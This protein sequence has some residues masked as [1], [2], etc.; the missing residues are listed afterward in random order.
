M[1]ELFLKDLELV[2]GGADS[3][4]DVTLSN[5]YGAGAAGGATV[6]ALL[7]QPPTSNGLAVASARGGAVSLAFYGGWKIGEALNEYTP[8]QSWLARGI[9]RVTGLDRSGSDYGDTSSSDKS[10]HNYGG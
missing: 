4:G 2:Y 6:H 7:H 10:G 1:K 5:S 3:N 9:D 8:I